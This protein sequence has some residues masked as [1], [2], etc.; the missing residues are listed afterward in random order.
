MIYLLLIKKNS[1]I[2]TAPLEVDNCMRIGMDVRA[3]SFGETGFSRYI[4]N[5]LY[6]LAKIDRD[7]TYIL[8]LNYDEPRLK[9]L[10]LS[11]NFSIRVIQAPFLI[12]KT[13]L[14]PIYLAKDRI[15]LFHS[16][17][18]DLPFF[19]FCKKLSTFYDLNI[20]LLPHLYIPKLRML[21]FFKISK[22]SAYRSDKIITIS[23]NTK[24]DMVKF[25]K[26]PPEKIKV[27]L[28]AVNE[29]FYPQ[30]REEAKGEIKRQY[31]VNFP[32]ILYVGQIRVQ[33]NIPRLLDAFKELKKKGLGHKL[34]L[35]GR[36]NTGSEFYNLSL[37]VEKRGLS[38]EVVHSS[39]CKNNEGLVSFYSA[40]DIFVY[41]SL[42]EG[43]G[44]PV[45]EAMA[46]KVPVVASNVASIPEVA[47]DAAILVNP[48]NVTEI[49]KAI[50]RVLTDHTLKD[51]LISRGL[52]RIK[53]FSWK[54][55]AEETLSVYQSLNGDSD[56]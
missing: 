38:G 6:N 26:I 51:T 32:F 52:K 35:V 55:T 19:I 42:Y 43:F 20:E 10:E 25:Y 41:P 30:D 5:L 34:V 47:K 23:E 14:L 4:L 27:T 56:N 7:N 24:K 8:Y 18:H 11:K 3:L 48:Y 2:C 12:Y 37:E 31:G 36:H 21:S 22:Y 9:A 16:M 44:L 45:L 54:R 28:L 40:A 1:R 15:D 50:H 39:N 49:A 29:D 17:T 13:L 53:D 46:C 33:K